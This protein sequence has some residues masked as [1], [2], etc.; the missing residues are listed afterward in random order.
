MTWR[1]SWGFDPGNSEIHRDAVLFPIAV[2][3]RLGA[4]AA[5]MFDRL[6]CG[7]LAAAPFLGFLQGALGSGREQARFFGHHDPFGRYRGAGVARS[8]CLI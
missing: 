8:I 3:H 4:I 7:G 6:A 2:T 1:M 5:T